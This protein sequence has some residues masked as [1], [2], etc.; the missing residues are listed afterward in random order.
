LKLSGRGDDDEITHGER[1]RRLVLP[2]LADELAI[3]LGVV[4]N[5]ALGLESVEHAVKLLGE[6][7]AVRGGQ[8]IKLADVA[9]ISDERGRDL[10]GLAAELGTNVKG[11]RVLALYEVDGFLTTADELRRKANLIGMLVVQLLLFKGLKLVQ[12][13]TDF[14]AKLICRAP[15]AV[16]SSL[17][18]RHIQGIENRLKHISDD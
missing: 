8:V 18:K 6:R 2:V 9:H 17:G 10:F 13:A 7:Q 1:H 3:V 11:R 5:G 16:C 15:D 14:F 4:N 12:A